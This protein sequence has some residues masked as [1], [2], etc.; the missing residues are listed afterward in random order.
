MHKLLPLAAR[1]HGC[2]SQ[3]KS[4]KEAFS[5]LIDED[6]EVQFTLFPHK[7]A[8]TG[9]VHSIFTCYKHF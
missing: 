2:H 3:I 6:I 1:R 5:F 8:E 4:T 7:V 9:C